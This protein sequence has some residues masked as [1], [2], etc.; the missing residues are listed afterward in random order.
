MKQSK[1]SKTRYTPGYWGTDEETYVVSRTGRIWCVQ[2]DCLRARGGR[3]AR[4]YELPRGAQPIN[5]WLCEDLNEPDE[6]WE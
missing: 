1:Q 6:C 2:S 3:P 5:D 4:C